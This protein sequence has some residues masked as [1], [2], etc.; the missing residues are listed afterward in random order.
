V[1]I[2]DRMEATTTLAAPNVALIEYK[3]PA[4]YAAADCPLCKAGAPIT[5]F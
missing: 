3:A 5:S 4:N 1:Q 2:V